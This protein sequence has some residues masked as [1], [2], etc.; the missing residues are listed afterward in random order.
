MITLRKNEIGYISQF[1]H[2]MPRRTALE[3]VEKALWE[4]GYITYIVVGAV[5]LLEMGATKMK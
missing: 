5:I 3:L 1:L 2:I 4:M